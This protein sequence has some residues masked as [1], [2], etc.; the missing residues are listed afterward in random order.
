MSPGDT[1]PHAGDILSRPP[2]LTIPQPV[3]HHYGMSAQLSSTHGNGSS[4]LFSLHAPAFQL[5]NT[6][7]GS[8]STSSPPFS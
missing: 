8:S 7:S 1:P 2:P 3:S 5:P 4:S 6:P